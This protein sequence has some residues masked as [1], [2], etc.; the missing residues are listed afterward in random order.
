MRKHFIMA[1]AALGFAACS[2][3]V[4]DPNTSINKGDLEESYIAIN[5]M[6]ADANTRAAADSYG[7]E[8]GIEAERAIKSAY[9]FF[10]DENGNPFNVTGAPAT[11]PDYNSNNRK[12]YL[13]LTITPTTGGTVENISDISKAVLVLNTYKGVYPSNIVAVINWT[14]DEKAYSL[15]ELH[16]VVENSLGNE[17]GGF[18]MSNSVYM[19]SD[20]NIVDAV[21]LT[22][23]NI[24]T[25]AAEAEEKP[26]EIYVER[27]AAKVV[28]T[29]S[30]KED[31]TTNI[32]A[33]GKKSTPIETLGDATAKDV[34]VQLH[35]WELYNDYNR[36]NLLKNIQKW[37]VA[38]L[39]LT[40]NDIPYY[41]SYWATSQNTAHNDEFA[42][43]Y[44]EQKKEEK[45]FQTNYGFN[46]ASSAN[47]T[48]R[49]TYTYCGENTNQ[50]DGDS[51]PRTKVILKGQLMQKNNNGTY[52][53]LEL[54]RWY[55]TEYAGN[56]A[57]RTAVA[58][59]LKYTLYSS[60]DGQNFSSI[61]P[62]D[63]QCVAGI[64][65]TEAY[66][67]G[68]ELSDDG[69]TKTWYQYSSQN[70][71]QSLGD[72]ANKVNQ[73]ATNT[74]LAN[75]VEPALVYTNGQTYYYIDIKHLGAEGKTAEY[76]VVRNHVYQIDIKSI[77]GYGS[78]IYIGTSNIVTPPEYPEDEEEPSYVAARINVL[79]WK[80]VKQ[81]VNIQ[82]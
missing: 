21:P 23:A 59:S 35:G 73:T 40:W 16:E 38:T 56:E 27:T 30:G 61:T 55:G 5:L 12:N 43:S 11:A 4:D 77:K 76:G 60:A 13:S 45:G 80:I 72:V 54:A 36:S 31:G 64:Q 6:A 48:D 2:E 24:K 79:S 44:T 66:E 1:L 71:Y 10:F 42:W 47:Y 74:Y 32:F 58:N 50:K 49:T 52:S 18:V 70:G 3:S 82:P 15:K 14:P 9:F 8:Y 17:T 37:D 53:T 62:E 57:L 68:F 7:Y 20:G 81:E 69:Q 29:A 26:V 33:T 41:R 75:N 51:D 78:P 34:Y 19:G 67:V 22:D 39:G 25:T 28:L 65:G 46:V 63:L